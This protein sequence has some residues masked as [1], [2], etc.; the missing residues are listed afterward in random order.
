MRHNLIELLSIVTD[1]QR[2][3]STPIIP[4]G[5]W[6]SVGLELR[7]HNTQHY[8]AVWLSFELLSSKV[9]MCERDS[10]PENINSVD[11][12]MSFQT[13]SL[14]NKK[15]DFENVLVVLFQLQL[16]GAEASKV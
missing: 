13:L 12:L 3:L 10:S 11:T 4:S 15:K 6:N 2:W 1:R 16:M 8:N 9:V 14:E 5:R 7:F